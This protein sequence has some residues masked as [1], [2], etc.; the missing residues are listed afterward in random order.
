MAS[1]RWSPRC[2]GCL[3]TLWTCKPHPSITR[4]SCILYSLSQ[5]PPRF[6]LQSSQHNAPS[7]QP[8]HC[9]LFPAGRLKTKGVRRPC[10][11]VR[12]HLRHD[13]ARLRHRQ[14]PPVRPS[15]SSCTPAP[16][17]SPGTRGDQRR[18]DRGPPAA[19]AGTEPGY[20]FLWLQ[21]RPKLY[22]GA[23]P[24]ST[25]TSSEPWP[26]RSCCSA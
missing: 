16:P 26:C 14:P 10:Q 23:C 9:S 2:R 24:E 13:G 21:V 20:P 25:S 11:T 3:T 6:R 22:P 18:P 15:A 12:P 8:Q 7:L 17:G 19:Q 4:K 5:P 1:S